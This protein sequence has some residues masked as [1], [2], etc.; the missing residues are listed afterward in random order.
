MFLVLG[1]ALAYLAAQDQPKEE[2]KSGKKKKKGKK[3]K[4]DSEQKGVGGA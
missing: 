4:K 2:P 3:V 1:G